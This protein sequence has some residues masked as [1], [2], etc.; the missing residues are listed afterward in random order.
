MSSGRLRTAVVVLVL[1]VPGCLWR[2]AKEEQIQARP[3]FALARRATQADLIHG[4][5]ATGRPGDYLLAND[6]IRVIVSDIPHSSGGSKSGGNII[7]AC[8]RRTKVDALGEMFTYFDD[9]FPRQAVYETL[10]IHRGGGGDEAAVIRVEGGDSTNPGLRVQTTYSLAPGRSYVTLTTEVANHSGG[11]QNAFDLGDAIQWGL[12]EHF[13]P[14]MGRELAGLRPRLEWLGSTGRGASYGVFVDR[15]EMETRHG[16]TWSD[17]IVSAPDIAAGQTVSYTRHFVVGIGGTSAVSDAALQARGVRTSR[18]SGRITAA[19]GGGG[20]A[21]ASINVRDLTGRLT[22][23]VKTGPDGRYAASLPAA[24]YML[25][26]KDVHRAAMHPFRIEIP[27]GQDVVFDGQLGEPGRVRVMA[28]D[29]QGAPVPAKFTFE[30]LRATPN[31]HFGPKYLTRGAGNVV[32]AATGQAWTPVAPGTYLVTASRGIEYAIAQATVSVNA[33]ATATVKAQLRRVVSTVGYVAADLH[34]H[35]APSFD[36]ALPLED[37]VISDVCEGIEV[38]AMT[39]HDVRTDLTPVIKRLGL[40]RRLKALVGNEV[41][42][43]HVG[44]FNAYPLPLLPKHPRHGAIDHKGKT[45]AA[46]FAELRA[47]APDAVIQVNH[48]R[49]GKLGYLNLAGFDR[50]TGRAASADF[51]LAFD[52]LEVFNGKHVAGAREVLGDWY[53][54]LNAG[55]RFTAVGGSDSHAA[56]EQEAGCP[57]TMLYVGVDEPARV[58]GAMVAGAIKDKRRAIVTNGPLIYLTVN[59]VGR[60][61]SQLTDTDGQVRVHVRVACAPWVKPNRFDLIRN[62]QTVLTRVLPTVTDVIRLDE[63]LKCDV[64]C[65]SW[66]VAVVSG[67]ASLEPVMPPLGGLLVTPLAFTNPVWI[68]ADGDGAFTPVQGA[69]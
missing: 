16:R 21:G 60:I 43:E 59:D 57:R 50:A 36:S 39:D 28:R 45:P 67:E 38:A 1:V 31:P 53:R 25:Q 56:T 4:L 19:K 37:R 30:G 14:G 18:L 9:T 48:P 32:F 3:A 13:A 23:I 8:D 33:G 42:T 62:G 40:Q 66:L 20:I 35:A 7:D 11:V 52:A 10:A 68:D 54:L 26:P 22:G 64:P 63:E 12:V 41:T 44:H 34:Q 65:D 49:A 24:I 29:G 51:S 61:G 2:L 55:H 47:L 15:G 46:L 27:S 17:I 6:R 58:T 69:R 5:A